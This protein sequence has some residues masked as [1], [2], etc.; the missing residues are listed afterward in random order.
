MTYKLRF[1]HDTREVRGAV[2]RLGLTETRCLQRYTYW[3][4]NPSTENI[5]WQVYDIVHV[6]LMSISLSCCKG[7]NTGPSCAILG[8]SISVLEGA[9]W[10]QIEFKNV[11]SDLENYAATTAT[12]ATDYYSIPPTRSTLSDD[13][14][15]AQ[16][17]QAHTCCRSL[18]DQQ[19]YYP[20]SRVIWDIQRA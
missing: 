9:W 15:D 4:H 13:S 10:N 19:Q 20:Q 1:V 11:T 6:P 5:V 8:D 16:F 18:K 3:L 12:V 17:L 7:C 14:S 2:E